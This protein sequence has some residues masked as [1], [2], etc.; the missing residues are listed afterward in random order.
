MSAIDQ[1]G[2]MGAPVIALTSKRALG[3]A[4]MTIGVFLA[5]RRR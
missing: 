5:V 3:L 2:L 4:L 1:F